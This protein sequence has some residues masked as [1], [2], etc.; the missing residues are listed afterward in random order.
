MINARI[1]MTVDVA[2]PLGIGVHQRA[3]AAPIL[4]RGVGVDDLG[5]HRRLESRQEPVVPIGEWIPQRLVGEGK[6]MAEVRI[7]LVRRLRESMVE[8]AAPRARNVRQQPIENLASV[9]IDV[10]TKIQKVP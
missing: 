1:V 9:L 10:Q 6:Q 5:P 3:V 4:G 7:G 8:C 2:C